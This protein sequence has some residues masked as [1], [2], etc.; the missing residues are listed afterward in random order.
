MILSEPPVQHPFTTMKVVWLSGL[1]DPATCA[2]SAKQERFLDALDVPHESK[3]Y[4]NFPYV[5]STQAPREVPLWLAS[6][7]NAHQFISASR[8]A[9][10]N[11]ARRHWRALADSTDALFV[12]TGSCGLEILNHCIDETDADRIVRV[13][14]LGPVARTRPNVPCTLVRGTNDPISKFYFPDCDVV[15]HGAGHMSYLDDP[16]V[17]QLVNQI[18]SEIVCSNTFPSSAPASICRSA[19]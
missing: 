17:V 14:A 10:R 15:L 5:P 1:S 12:I 18:V 4:W 9:Y 8:P 11:A 19:S 13:I 6:L 3:I 7:R 16:R 2:L